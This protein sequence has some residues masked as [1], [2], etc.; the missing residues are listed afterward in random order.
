MSLSSLPREVLLEIIDY[1]D[2]APTNAL[3]YTNSQIYYF[4]NQF[5]YRQDVV[6][7]QSKSLT[8]AAENGMEGTIQQAINAGQ[9]FTPIPE[10]FNIA[11]QD[12]ADRGHVRLVELLLQVDG[13]NLNFRGGSL[14]TT[15]LGLAARNGHSAIVELLLAADDVDPDA[16]NKD[17]L[18]PLHWACS[19]KHV[20]IVRQLLVRDDVNIN[21]IGYSPLHTAFI[22]PLI[23]AENVE[24]INLLLA[25]DGIDVNLPGGIDRNTPLMTVVQLGLEEVAKSLLT[26]GDLN[27]N[28]VNRYGD[29]VLITAAGLEM[30]GIVKLLLDHPGIDTTFVTRHGHKALMETSDPDV[31]R[32]LLDQ[33]D[34]EVNRQDYLGRTALCEAA[35]CNRLE[36]AKLLLERKDID[37]N[38]PENTGYNALQLAC[39]YDY[40]TL[41][42]LLLERDDIDPNFRDIDNGRTALA[43][44]CHCPCRSTAIVRLLL[45]HPDTD[46]NA[47]DNDGVSILADFVNCR[48]HDAVNSPLKYQRDNEI[49]SLLRAAGAL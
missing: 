35:W 46:P 15:P 36:A 42:G 37:V 48:N 4:I 28:I 47:V 33:K 11:L 16:R 41:V 6:K 21:A 19:M 32:L 29:H 25:K 40:Q 3:A 14:K 31:V 12:A 30:A 38:L 5:L 20:P 23:A 39:H 2:D 17:Y 8:W 34:I 44:V 13:I 26:R 10:N 24:I 18:T 27:P 43:H 1:L 22:T 9:H 7:P 49:E 45:S